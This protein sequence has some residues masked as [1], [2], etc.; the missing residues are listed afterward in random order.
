MA[1]GKYQKWLEKAQLEQITNWAAHG[2]TDAEIAQN[3]GIRRTTLYDWFI[4]H[5]DISDAVKKGREMCIEHVENAFFR[6]AMGL[7]EEVT[8]TKDIEQKMVDG[9]LVTVHKQIRTTVKKLPPD[10]SALIFY[11][12]N[13]AGYRSEPEIEVNVETTPRFYF[14]RAEL[15]QN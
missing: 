13:K 1:K 10:T 8:E 9:Q 5:P 2:C 4:K 12:K 3:I 7:V 6:R 15:E 11:L 14:D